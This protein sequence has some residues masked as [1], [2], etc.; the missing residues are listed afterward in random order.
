M[1]RISHAQLL[2]PTHVSLLQQEAMVRG[3][4]NLIKHCCLHTCTYLLCSSCTAC[5]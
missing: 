3:L 4:Y 1:H 2:N 5:T